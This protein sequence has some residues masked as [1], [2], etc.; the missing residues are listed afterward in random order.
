MEFNNKDYFQNNF[1]LT[2]EEKELAKYYFK[3]HDEIFRLE[4]NNTVDL[5]SEKIKK[6]TSDKF[7]PLMFKAIIIMKENGAK[8]IDEIDKLDSNSDTNKFING[9]EWKCIEHQSSKINEQLEIS[10]KEDSN[11]ALILS[12]KIK[13]GEI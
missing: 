1:E 2:N 3:I 11:E 8:S 10:Q 12:E 13:S 9:Y 6:I 7:L 5:L 4:F